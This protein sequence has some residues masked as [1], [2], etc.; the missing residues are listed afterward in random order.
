MRR[1]RPGPVR[2]PRTEVD[3]GLASENEDDDDDDDDGGDDNYLQDMADEQA[4]DSDTDDRPS[5]ARQKRTGAGTNTSGSTSTTS[6]AKKRPTLPHTSD[7]N[8][9]EVNQLRVENYDTIS[10]D[11]TDHYINQLLVSRKIIVNPRPPPDVLAE[12]MALQARYR[13]NKKVLCLVGHISEHT[14]DA[15]M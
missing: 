3:D 1:R 15:E 8:Q 5:Q 11:W 4:D 13:R 14:L 9:A 6:K 7:P 10:L 12:A 2:A